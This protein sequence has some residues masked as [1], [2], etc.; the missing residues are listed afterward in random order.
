[1]KVSGRYALSKRCQLAYGRLL[2]ITML[3]AG[4]CARSFAQEPSLALLPLSASA[5]PASIGAIDVV[6]VNRS[7]G[8]EVFPLGEQFA[9]TMSAGGSSWSVILRAKRMTGE[10]QRLDSMM[11]GKSSSIQ[12]RCA[13]RRIR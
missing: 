8:E 12:R 10:S 5:A 9:A 3:I 6:V 11:A 2:S 4:L 7:T 13:G 1:V